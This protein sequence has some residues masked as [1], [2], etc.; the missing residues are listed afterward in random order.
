MQAAQAAQATEQAAQQA[1]Q[2]ADASA[3]ARGSVGDASCDGGDDG[4]SAGAGGDADGGGADSALRWQRGEMLGAGSF[5]TVYLGFN[6]S[7]GE[8]MAVK[9][10]AIGVGGGAHAGSNGAEVLASI[11]AEISCLQGLRHPNIVRY[12]GVERDEAKGTL[13]IFLEYVAG[14][15]IHA[16]L[17]KFGAFSESLCRRYMR[18][19]L[20]GVHYLHTHKIVH[21]CARHPPGQRARAWSTRRETAAYV[22]SLIH[23]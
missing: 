14:G 3:P 17:S 12:L 16:L 1:A 2:Q 5:G 19:I 7:S 21:R 22:L 11:E 6:L 15:S 20:E 18:H 9:Q 13:S 23:I 8:M 4:G 10:M